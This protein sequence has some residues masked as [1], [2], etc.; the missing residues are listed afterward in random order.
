[1]LASIDVIT[2]IAVVCGLSF[3]VL[4]A[5]I[6]SPWPRDTH[7]PRRLD[8]DVETRLLLREDPDELADELDAEED[9]RSSVAEIRRD[10]RRSG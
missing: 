8:K 3:V 6:L 9:A 5:I 10:E 7:D 4:L 1:M 2:W